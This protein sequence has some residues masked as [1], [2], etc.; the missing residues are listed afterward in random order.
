MM[1]FLQLHQVRHCLLQTRCGCQGQV[2]KKAFKVTLWFWQVATGQSVSH[3]IV[4]HSLLPPYDKILN[5]IVQTDKVSLNSSS[6]NVFI[7]KAVMSL[8]HLEPGW[9][10]SDVSL[11]P[12]YS[13]NSQ[14]PNLMPT[15]SRRS[16]GIRPTVGWFSIW[17]EEESE[18]RS[19]E[20]WVISFME[21]HSDGNK[22]SDRPFLVST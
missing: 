11:E 5:L 3:C 8:L 21:P 2:K 12:G 15:G 19:R 10:N 20:L 16:P 22:N 18:D 4:R 6:W 17:D 1:F 9:S 7:S 13:N 14:L